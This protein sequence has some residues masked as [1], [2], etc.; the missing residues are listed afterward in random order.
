[1]VRIKYSVPLTKK[2]NV[3]PKLKF[4]VKCPNRRIGAQ[5]NDKYIAEIFDD[6]IYNG[7][8]TITSKK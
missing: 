3:R 7:K 5:F 2:R 8:G 1:M 4:K 6:H